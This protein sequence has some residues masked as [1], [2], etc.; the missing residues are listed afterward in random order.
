ML[1]Y[2]HK[3]LEKCWNPAWI[4][5]LK[6]GGTLNSQK[7]ISSPDT[8]HKQLKYHLLTTHKPSPHHSTTN[9]LFISQNHLLATHKETISHKPSLH[10]SQLNHLLTTPK[11]SPHHSQTNHLT[12]CTQSLDYSQKSHHSQQSPH[13]T[14]K[15]SPHHSQTNHLFTIHKQSISDHLQTI[16]S[17]TNAIS[18]T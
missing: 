16:S 10:H 2:Q 17:L 15:P 12:T 3:I 11:P 13:H 9:Y 4:C 8:T 14:N 1:E 18:I 7:T 6:C 5:G